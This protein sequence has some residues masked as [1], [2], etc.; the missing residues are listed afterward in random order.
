MTD[1]GICKS[2]L[3]FWMLPSSNFR[4]KGPVYNV[5]WH[6][7]FPTFSAMFFRGSYFRYSHRFSSEFMTYSCRITL[8]LS[9]NCLSNITSN[10]FIIRDIIAIDLWVKLDKFW[11]KKK[12]LF[13]FK[14]Y[15]CRFKSE[16]FAS[17][18]LRPCTLV[19]KVSNSSL[20]DSVA[21]CLNCYEG[22]VWNTH[23]AWIPTTQQ[24][25]YKWALLCAIRPFVKL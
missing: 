19:K 18:A 13:V 1:I 4:F 6:D 17:I 3:M 23:M 22:T 2:T 24:I 11:R 15:T 14:G 9:N 21:S 5:K 8:S 16:A 10:E 7:D 25:A 12:I 20:H